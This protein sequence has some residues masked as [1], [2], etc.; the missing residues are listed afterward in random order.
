MNYYKEAE[1]LIKKSKLIRVFVLYK[2]IVKLYTPTGISE[3]SSSKL[4]AVR[5]ELS[6]ATV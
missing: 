5:Q 4:K 2:T 1:N 3:D 6:M